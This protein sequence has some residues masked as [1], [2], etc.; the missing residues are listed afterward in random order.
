MTWLIILVVL[1]A[2][3]AP[4]AYMMPTKRDRAL[5]DL[6]MIARREGLEVD[7]T[8][9]P[10]LNAE[11][12]ERVSASGKAREARL[13]CVSYG[14]RLPRRQLA[15]VRYRLLRHENSDF[16]LYS[17]SSP[18]KGTS[19]ELDRQFAPATEPAPTSDYWRVLDDVEALLPAD[20]LGLAVTDDFVLFYWKERLRS[21][22]Q[23]EQQGVQNTGT[24]TAAQARKN[25]RDSAALVADIRLLLN[26]VA[27]F[28][29]EF[30]APP[31]PEP[32]LD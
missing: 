30:F 26:K 8:H 14:L 2:A 12:H 31:K 6:R 5:S 1:A 15:P 9:L 16:P 29:E 7:V 27:D 23:G 4:V 22:Q 13:D 25:P 24:E 11:P 32:E 10:K 17:G 3:F 21:E 18:D 20:T 19:W 28:H